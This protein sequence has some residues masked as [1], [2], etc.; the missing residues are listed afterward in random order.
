MSQR[1][2]EEDIKY[3]EWKKYQK[4]YATWIEKGKFNSEKIPTIKKFF[5]VTDPPKIKVKN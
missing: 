2:A 4:E 1:N 5:G 3:R